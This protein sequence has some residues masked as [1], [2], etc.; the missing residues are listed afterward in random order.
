MDD[1]VLA[2]FEQRSKPLA[3]RGPFRLE[4]GARRA[5]VADRQ[6][7][8]VHAS[9]LNFGAEIR[10]AKPDI[11]CGSISV[12][13][14]LAFHSAIASRSLAMSRA[15]VSAD[16]KAIVLTW[17]E[18]DADP[19]AP[20]ARVDRI[21]PQRMRL[22]GPDHTVHRTCRFRRGCMSPQWSREGFRSALLASSG[23][24]SAL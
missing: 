19:A 15:H 11:S 12:T 9:A 4:L 20:R 14:A 10:N 7:E 13:T 18:G 17:G 2:S 8:P 22:A 21:D 24:T 1:N 6:M 5:H 16:R 3:V 23:R